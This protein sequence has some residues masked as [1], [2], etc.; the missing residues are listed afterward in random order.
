MKMEKSVQITS[1]IVVG[2]I[3]LAIIVVFGING[4]STTQ[5]TVSV[6][7]QSTVEVMPD[8]VSVYFSVDTKGTT[9]KEASDKNTD[10]TNA[11]IAALESNGFS[12]EDIQTQSYSVYP[13]Y[14]WNSGSQRL[15]D[16]KASHSL[17]V[18]I[19]AN[20]SDKIGN[21]VDSGINAGAGVSYI[22]FE[23]SQESQNKYK[24]EAMKLAAQDATTKAESVADGLNKKL[25]SLVSV[26]VDSYNYMPW[27]ARD[28]AGA[29]S[30]EVE[31]AVPSIVPSTQEISASVTA[32]FKIR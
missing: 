30:A 6:A 10:I 11:L 28:F 9:S 23:L 27:L 3:I 16:Y 22:N 5:N 8:L 2:A 14:D 4:I 19:P 12:R 29:T 21:A 1:L 15:I 18:Q 20:E 25:G 24:A 7:G 17:K 32:V 26:S 31:K 13:E